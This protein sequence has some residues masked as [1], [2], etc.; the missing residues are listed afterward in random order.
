MT[1][2]EYIAVLEVCT[3]IMH[4]KYIAEFMG[5]RINLL[6]LVNVD[7]IGAVYLANSV[8]GTQRTKHV[9]VQ[10]HFVCEYV[11]DDVVQIVFV[12]SKD[13]VADPFTKNT[14]GETHSHHTSGYMG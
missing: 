10:Y 4:C 9:N 14:D 8:Q 3:E 2:V 11:E 6:I 5:I 1:E 13:N 7:N 12:K